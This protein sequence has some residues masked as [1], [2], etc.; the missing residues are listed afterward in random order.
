MGI[1]GELEP[2]AVLAKLALTQAE[3]EAA[4]PTTPVLPA[5]EYI[6]MVAQADAGTDG[7]YRAVMPIQRLIKL[8]PWPRKLTEL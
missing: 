3:W 6:A 5:I 1:L 4:D 2:E 8:M 7:K